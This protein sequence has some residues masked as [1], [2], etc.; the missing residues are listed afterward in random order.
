MCVCVCAG[1]NALWWDQISNVAYGG[2]KRI[3]LFQGPSCGIWHSGGFFFLQQTIA[4]YN[5]NNNKRVKHLHNHL[6]THHTRPFL[7]VFQCG[8]SYTKPNCDGQM[9]NQNKDL[10]LVS[11]QTCLGLENE[12]SSPETVGIK[13]KRTGQLIS[14]TNMGWWWVSL[15][16]FWGVLVMVQLCFRCETQ[17]TWMEA[18]CCWSELSSKSSMIK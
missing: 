4:K 14:C 15:V 2:F 12:I 3:R 6:C 5:N 17:D 7:Q 9:D 8:L 16:L 13:L 18:D 11:V 10:A 1:V